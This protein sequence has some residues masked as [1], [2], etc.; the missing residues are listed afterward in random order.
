MAFRIGSTLGEANIVPATDADSS[1]SPTNAPKLGSWPLPP[2]ETIETC[3]AWP[4]L[5]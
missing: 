4:G 5:R 2:P 3:E 1:P